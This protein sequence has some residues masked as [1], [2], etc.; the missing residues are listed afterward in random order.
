MSDYIGNPPLEKLIPLTRGCDY[1]F[2]IQRTD[3]DG[4]PVEFDP[5]TE[6]YLWLDIDKEN[7]TKVDG[8]VSG[9][10]AAITIPDSVADEARNGCRWRAV[11]DV[12]EREVPLLVGRI[13]RH[14]G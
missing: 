4:E 13:E 1:S 9:S 7:P 6:V 2:T 3:E 11:L 14:D 5:D 12:G 10:T 8:F